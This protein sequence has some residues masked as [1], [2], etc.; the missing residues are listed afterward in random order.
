MIILTRVAMRVQSHVPRHVVLNLVH[1]DPF[2]QNPVPH[3]ANQ[4]AAIDGC[5]ETILVN[6]IYKEKKE[7]NI[8]F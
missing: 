5:G 7:T 1:Q 4:A 2:V 3:P 6:G 8:N